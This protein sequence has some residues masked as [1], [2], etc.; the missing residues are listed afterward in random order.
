MNKNNIDKR[1][2]LHVMLFL[3]LIPVKAKVIEQNTIK[4]EVLQKDVSY[5]I[6]LPPDYDTSQRSY[7]VIYLL[8]GYGDD[9]TTW[10][11][12]GEIDRYADKA[13]ADGL[14]PPVI[15]IMAD[16][17]VSMYVNSYNKKSMYEDYFIQEFI[18]TVEE[19]YRIR[20]TKWSRGIAGHSMGGWG[21]ML[22]AL[23]YPDMFVASAPM[24]AGIHD[25][26][27][28]MNYDDG[29]WD[30]I[31][32]DIIGHN[33]KGKDRLNKVWYDNSI[34]HIIKNKSSDDIRKVHYRISCGDNDSLIR[35]SI[36]LH[37]ALTDKDIRHEFRIGDGGHTWAYWRSEITDVL[38]FITDLI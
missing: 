34:L 2:T 9:H 24:S 27:E 6:Y 17:G 22:Y 26:N 1:F 37:Q 12:R 3:F 5:S 4:S 31:F 33:I 32:G 21:C 29:R 38:K 11:Q 14:I 36:S 23:K 20:K 25:D 30:I 18:P 8:H 7:P 13:I 35:G 16:A 19:R 10:I 28:I 15:I